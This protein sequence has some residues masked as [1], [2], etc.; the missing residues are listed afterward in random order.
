MNKKVL[1]L[2]NFG[3]KKFSLKL[4]QKEVILSE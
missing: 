3:F 4:H 2:E 1:I